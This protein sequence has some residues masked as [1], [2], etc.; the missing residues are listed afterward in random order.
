[1]RTE[2]TFLKVLEELFNINKS[3]SKKKN[4]SLKFHSKLNLI[5]V[6]KFDFCLQINSTADDISSAT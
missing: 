2:D 5:H 4:K 1:M 3:K 6:L